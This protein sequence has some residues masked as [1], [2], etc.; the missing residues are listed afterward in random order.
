MKKDKWKGL[1]LGFYKGVL[2]AEL[3]RKRIDASDWLSAVTAMLWR[4]RT[5]VLG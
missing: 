5:E 2:L 1:A 3:A 4:E